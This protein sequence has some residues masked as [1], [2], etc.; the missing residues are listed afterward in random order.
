MNYSEIIRPP[1]RLLPPGKADIR[2]N[3]DFI[4]RAGMGHPHCRIPG[5]RE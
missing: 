3:A 5:I 1:M 2:R 4:T